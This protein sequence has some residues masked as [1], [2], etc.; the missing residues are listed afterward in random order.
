MRGAVHPPC[1]ARQVTTTGQQARTRADAVLR[2]G[3]VV[4]VVGLLCLLV[5][6]IPLFFSSVH[7]PGV[8]WFAAMLTGVGLLVVFAGLTM[9]A[10][11]R[12]GTGR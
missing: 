8:M 10:R 4:V 2:A 7:L 11:G 1:Q 6:I 12:R 3:V 9:G 5:A